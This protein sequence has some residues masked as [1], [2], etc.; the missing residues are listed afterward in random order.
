MKTLVIYYSRTGNTRLVAQEIVTTLRTDIEELSEYTNRLGLIGWL[1][2]GRDAFMKR[3]TRLKPLKKNPGEY[4]LLIIGTPI[5]AG[6]MSPAIRTYISDNNLSD[7]KI[8]LFCTADG[9]NG[10]GIKSIKEMLDDSNIISELTVL[11]TDMKETYK[12][13]VIEWAGTLD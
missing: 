13:K 7:K 11:K 6:N 1:K 3:K 2:S 4:D 5:W 9:N 12:E 10:K 8:A